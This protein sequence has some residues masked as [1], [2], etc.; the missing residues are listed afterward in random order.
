MGRRCLPGTGGNPRTPLRAKQ[1]N[2]RYQRRNPSAGVL[3]EGLR[4]SRLRPPW[5]PEPE[6]CSGSGSPSAIARARSVT[7]AVPGAG[8]VEAEREAREPDHKTDCGAD[9]RGCRTVG[10]GASCSDDDG[11]ANQCGD[12]VKPL[13]EHDGDLADE[14]VAEDA[15]ADARDRAKVTRPAP[16]ATATSLRG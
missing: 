13:S 12:R 3:R 10:A 15:A 14:D 9:D 4:G 6:R 16:P 1:R 7:V 5:Q 8:E 11:G 2:R